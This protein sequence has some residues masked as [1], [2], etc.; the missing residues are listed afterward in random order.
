MG[1]AEPQPIPL[2][3]DFP[4][5]WD[6]P[7]DAKRFWTRDRMHTPFPMPLLAFEF[8][9]FATGEGMNRGHELYERPIRML[10]RRINCYLFGSIRMVVPPA[11]IATVARQG[12]QNTLDALPGIWERWETQWLPEVKE[13]LAW[14]DAFDL[15]G[16]SIPSLRSHLSE[17]FEKS[18]RCWTIHFSLAPLITGPG[19]MFRDLYTDLF[20]EDRGLESH[21]LTLAEDNKS[22][23]TDRELWRLSRHL[24]GADNAD[25]L[26]ES[27][28]DDD[29]RQALG[30]RLDDFL[31]THGHR[32]GDGAG[33]AGLT[34]CEE[35][36]PVIATV[37]AYT[38]MEGADP[39]DEHSARIAERDRLVM[40]A[41]DSIA[42]YPRAV[43][44]RFDETLL[45]AQQGSRLQE[46][47]AYW[48]DQRSN[49]CAHYVAMEA[50][51]RLVDAG[52][53]KA[54][55]DVFHLGLNEILET[56]DRLSSGDIADLTGV[57][58][59]RAADLAHWSQ[60]EA[61]TE[62]GVR[63][64]GGRP[65]TVTARGQSRFFG[66]PTEQGDDPSTVNGTP[67]SPGVAEGIARIIITLA[68]TG[69]LSPGD[70]LVAPTTSP[71]WTPLFRTASAVVTDAGGVL[72]HCAVVAREYGIPAI[73][74]TGV[75]T[76]RIKDGQRVRVDGD[77][78][79]VRIL[80]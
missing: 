56:L 65:D 70:V 9:Q 39:E 14:W 40:K 64:I 3:P 59:E 23:E 78:G 18:A 63:P 49:A 10:R 47:H 19:S 66:T 79:E 42:G 60:V 77:A 24:R 32:S 7:E 21:G 25:V 44:E 62:I 68:D 27:G 15:P 61:P 54:P 29:L 38:G 69:K 75:G 43:R 6:N 22:L 52:A 13:H 11:E 20:G 46:D 48:I 36:G 55:S 67:A 74:G 17:S 2:P 28:S 80:D 53:L 1:A 30:D 31:A 8:F 35:P 34:W 33:F 51:R 37:R 73:V 57:V 16:A 5:E 26:V 58:Q 71:P 72:S 50:G 76:A 12:E 41:R 45:L 4:V